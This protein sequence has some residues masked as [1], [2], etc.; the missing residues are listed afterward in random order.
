[1][2]TLTRTIAIV[3]LIMSKISAQTPS[4][5][6]YKILNKNLE[7][8]KN[9]YPNLVQLESLC[10]TAGGRNVLLAKLG[11]GEVD[12][13]PAVLLVAGVNGTDLAGTEI[14]MQFIQ[15]CTKTYSLIDTVT[16]MLDH[17]TFYILPRVN[18][19]AAEAFF[20]R[21]VYARRLNDR[22]LDLDKDGNV[23]ED[24]YDDINKDGLITQ[25]RIT[26]SGG[27]WLEDN[28]FPGLLC[29]ADPGQLSAGQ[30]QL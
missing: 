17:T 4:Y 11:S 21:P 15:Y 6:D 5:A 22:P 9:E 26:E 24:G 18:P 29:K 16:D 27:E 14:M 19:D 13:K 20:Q 23:N 7:K 25:M 28:D 3:I 30:A 8:I 2:T 1:M 10:T 12:T